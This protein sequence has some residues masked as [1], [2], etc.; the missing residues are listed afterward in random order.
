MEARST[1][2]RYSGRVFDVAALK[3][4]RDILRTQVLN[5]GGGVIGAGV[6]S[7]KVAVGSLSCWSRLRR[8]R[9][10][11][12]SPRLSRNRRVTRDNPSR[13]ARAITAFQSDSGIRPP[14]SL[15]LAPVRE[16][17]GERF[18]C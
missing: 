7:I 14:G 6:S 8:S 16:L 2:K 12:R 13:S 17:F 10:R 18:Q 11:L 5:R 3:Q 1:E 9:R 4:V 15:L